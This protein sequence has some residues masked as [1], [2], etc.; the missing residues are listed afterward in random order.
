[1]HLF[2]KIK[3]YEDRQLEV[4]MVCRSVMIDFCVATAMYVN[5]AFD[6][7]PVINGLF[8]RYFVGVVQRRRV[9]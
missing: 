5:H 6:R 3:P 2:K 1:M 4:C 8:I 7:S 9:T